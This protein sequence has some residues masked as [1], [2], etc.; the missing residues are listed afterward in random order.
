MEHAQS[1]IFNENNRHSYFLEYVITNRDPQ[2]LSQLTQALKNITQTIK[3]SNVIAFGKRLWQHID[4]EQNPL[5]FNDFATLSGPFGHTAPATQHDLLIWLYDDELDN[6]FDAMQICQ[7]QLAELAILALEC[8]GFRYKD[9][10]DLTG[11]VD[12]S[13]NPKDLA[14]KAEAALLPNTHSHAGG[15]FVLTQKWVHDLSEFAKMP[16]QMQEKVI[17][18]TKPDSIEL[19]GDDMPENSHVSRTDVK[20]DN[21]AMKLYRR[22]VPFGN[23][24]EKGL[25]FLG[26]A[27]DQQRFQIQLERMFGLTNDGIYDKLIDFSKAVNSAYWFAPSQ[28]QLNALFGK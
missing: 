12:G 23:A 13:A 27:C 25:Y 24:N 22:S 8:P 3:C 21:V 2:T 14:A 19:E 15:S 26:F 9:N 5:E 16:M 11:F 10:R 4:T 17:G 28:Q 18:R 7:N 6:V 20:V 1:G